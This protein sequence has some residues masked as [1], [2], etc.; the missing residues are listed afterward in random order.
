MRSFP[1]LARCAGHAAVAALCLEAAAR[2]DDALSHGAPIWGRYDAEVLRVRDDEGLPRNV[3]G[4]S[5][6]KWR[7]NALGFR[8]EAVPVAKPSGHLRVACVGTSETFGLHEREGG[9]WPARL[10]RLLRERGLANAEVINASALALNR[11]S[12]WRYVEKYVLPL[13]PDVLVLYWNVLSDATYHA[14]SPGADDV[15]AT[16]GAP[17]WAQAPRS[18]VLPKLRR[19]ARQVVPDG[20]W[21]R[22]RAWSTARALRRAESAVLRGARPLDAVPPAAVSAFDAHLRVLVAAVRERGIVPLLATYPTLG[23]MANR[24]RD[25]LEALEE[26]VWH[27]ELSDAGMIQAAATLNEVVRRVAREL[28]VPL[29]DAEAAVPKDREHLADYLHYTDAGAARVAEAVLAALAR[30]GL[31]ED[32]SPRRVAA[33]GGPGR[34]P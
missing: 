5:F 23:T 16:P 9:E 14:P 19:A 13:R 17:A 29:V 26:R 30:E 12:R 24:D 18:R 21:R 34:A 11:A 3:P 32:G 10:G 7:I 22:Y 20:I 2:L 8:G 25:R 4:T 27:L 15:A 1:A 28:G 6:E 33:G 31:L